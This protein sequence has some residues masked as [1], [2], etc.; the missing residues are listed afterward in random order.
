MAAI[1]IGDKVKI[2]AGEGYHVLKVDN[3]V[4]VTGFNPDRGL[5]VEG[6][7]MGK[8][9]IQHILKEHYE[10]ITPEVTTP[11]FEDRNKT[12]YGI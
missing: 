11:V 12:M 10:V 5:I 7:F 3:V 8:K 1:N 2:I 6:E 9:V 4:E